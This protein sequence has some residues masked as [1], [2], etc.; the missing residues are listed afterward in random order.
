MADPR[1]IHRLAK[2]GLAEIDSMAAVHVS[3]ADL[4]SLL[5]VPGPEEVADLEE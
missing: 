1:R 4:A 5:D 3:A 2:A